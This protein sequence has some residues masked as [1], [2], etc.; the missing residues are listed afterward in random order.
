MLFLIISGFIMVVCWIIFNVFHNANTSTIS[1]S[2]AA[3][4]IPIAPNFD[5]Q[6]IAQ[7]KLR[8]KIPPLYQTAIA[9]PSA[10]ARPQIIQP[11]ISPTT[12]PTASQEGKLNQ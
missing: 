9:T 8:K 7:L 2:L 6:T 4:I 10:I 11:Q 5:T 12:L 3:D 1:S